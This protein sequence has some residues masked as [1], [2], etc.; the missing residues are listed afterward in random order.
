MKTI[1]KKLAFLSLLVF[2]ITA[3]AQF[4]FPVT[5]NDL[6][7]NLSKVISDFPNQFSSF[8]GDTIVNNPQ[9]VEFAS[10]LDFKGAEKN[11]ITQY[12]S[13]NPVY[14]WK[15]RLLKS[16]EFED[17]AKKYKW[18]VNQLRVMTIKLNDGYSFT[19]S[20]H[21]DPADQSKAFSSSIFSLTP[22]AT[23]LPKLKIEA[24]IEFNFPEWKVYLLVFEKEREDNEQGDINGN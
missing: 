19:L 22:A 20:G 6:R 10:L 2:A 21:Y 23:N 11:S 17:A 8:K 18:L 7:N 13:A 16:E 3:K 12:K 14:S 24:S 15:A 9:S 4:K 5:N 1:Q